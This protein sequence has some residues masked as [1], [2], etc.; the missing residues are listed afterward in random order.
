MHKVPFL[1]SSVP[2]P[3]R[4]LSRAF[5]WPWHPAY[6][7]TSCWSAASHWLMPWKSASRKVGPRGLTGDLNWLGT[8]PCCM[9]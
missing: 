7:L 1:H 9:G 4:V 6:S 2:R 3:G 5:A 8:D